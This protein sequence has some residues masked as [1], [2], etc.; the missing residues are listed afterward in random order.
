MR[1]AAATL[2]MCIWETVGMRGGFIRGDKF[3]IT[4]KGEFAWRGRM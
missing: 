4:K 1:T 3:R 2:G